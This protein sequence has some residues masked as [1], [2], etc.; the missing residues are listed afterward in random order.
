MGEFGPWHLLIVAG[1]F[2][3][4]FGAKRLPEAA[5]SLGKSARIMKTELHSLHDE[6][7]APV[8][9]PVA[10]PAAATDAH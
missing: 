7:P 5:R 9:A 10:V 2:V 1:V 8:A 6:T 3:L 4:L